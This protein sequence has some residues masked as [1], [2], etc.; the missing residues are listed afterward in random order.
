MVDNP[1]Y[2]GDIPVYESIL[3]HS[4]KELRSKLSDTAP[5]SHYEVVQAPASDS[6]TMDTARYIDHSIIPRQ[7]SKSVTPSHA[8]VLRCDDAT[9]AAIFR[10][11]SVSFPA[12]RVGIKSNGQPRNKLNLRLSLEASNNNLSPIVHTND[13]Y[14]DMNTIGSLS[15]KVKTGLESKMDDSMNDA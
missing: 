4:D 14:I 12:K 13:P 9:E 7:H 1:I 3:I 10:S 11:N 6:Q 15:Q 2:V 5:T 8:S